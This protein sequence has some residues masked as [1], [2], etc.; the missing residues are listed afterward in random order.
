MRNYTDLK[1]DVEE[2]IE[3]HNKGTKEIEKINKAFKDVFNLIQVVAEKEKEGPLSPEMQKAGEDSVEYFKKL[4][5]ILIDRMEASDRL[6]KLIIDTSNEM[7]EAGRTEIREM[8]AREEAVKVKD[9]NT[10]VGHAGPKS[11]SKVKELAKKFA[12]KVKETVEHRRPKH[13]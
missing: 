7:H 13:T 12:S 11:T 8:T 6:M 10:R 3:I 4:E 5:K 1:A 9:I 2:L